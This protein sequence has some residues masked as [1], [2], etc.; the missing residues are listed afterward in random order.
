MNKSGKWQLAPAY[1]LCYSYSPS[2]KWTSQHQLSLN[3][4]RD[5]FTKKDLLEIGEKT[6]VKNS[7]SIIQQIVETVSQWES[8]ARN[9]GVKTN[10][11]E[12]IQKTLRINLN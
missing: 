11:T 12:Q 4:K 3:G 5:D 1:D 9:A 6:G 10:H 2:G 8:Y 7:K